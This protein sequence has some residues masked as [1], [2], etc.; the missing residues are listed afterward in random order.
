MAS[1]QAESTAIA[2]RAAALAWGDVTPRNRDVRCVDPARVPRPATAP[3]AGGPQ[4]RTRW[5]MRRSPGSSR[6]AVAPGSDRRRRSSFGETAP[7]A[8]AIATDPLRPAAHR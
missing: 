2:Q 3:L 1:G 6:G 7:G 5:Y 4:D 8:A